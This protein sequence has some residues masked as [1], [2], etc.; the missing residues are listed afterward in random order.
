MH[1]TV[2]NY[3]PPTF[4][5]TYISTSIYDY[6][7]L[8][9]YQPVQTPREYQHREN[10]EIYENTKHI[11]LRRKWEWYIPYIP[12]LPLKHQNPP[13]N[14]RILLGIFEQTL[15]IFGWKYL[16]SIKIY[17][18][19]YEQTFA[20]KCDQKMILLYLHWKIISSSIPE[21]WYHQACTPQYF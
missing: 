12:W 2:S 13:Q 5:S 19:K 18:C 11:T 10:Y 8:S 20:R 1:L 15:R 16:E 6:V 17:S 3:H 14:H 9:I 21:G 7:C 4:L